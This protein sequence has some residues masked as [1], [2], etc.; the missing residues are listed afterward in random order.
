MF[1]DLVE[2]DAR[3]PESLPAGVVAG[4]IRID[5]AVESA[6]IEEGLEGRLGHRVDGFV[7]A[8]AIHVAHIG[9]GGIFRAGARP[10]RALRTGTEAGE[11]ILPVPGVVLD[12]ASVRESTLVEG[13]RS[14]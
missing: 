3:F 2:I 10:E 5:G 4:G 6:V 13:G 1:R 8:Q 14:A 12:I 9:V 7:A 11:S